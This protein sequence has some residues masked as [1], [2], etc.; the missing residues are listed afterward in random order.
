LSRGGYKA[1]EQKMIKEKYDT[2]KAAA[3]A[4]GQDST[5]IDIDHIHISR[6]EKWKESKKSKSGN[7]V[8][9]ESRIVATRVVSII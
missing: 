9:E 1:L 6:E 4:E 5:S 7:Y 3:E 2:L 8:S